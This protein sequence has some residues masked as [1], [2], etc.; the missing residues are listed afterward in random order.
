MAG[1]MAGVTAFATKS[2]RPKDVKKVIEEP[3]K[4]SSGESVPQ[5]IYVK[6][7]HMDSNG[8]WKIQEYTIG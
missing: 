8:S 6:Y 7:G 2:K 4:L 3:L 5:K 1:G